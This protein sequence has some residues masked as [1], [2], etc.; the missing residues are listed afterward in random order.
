[1]K[2]G[3]HVSACPPVD[4]GAVRITML[5]RKAE[6][7]GNRFAYVVTARA[8]MPGNRFGVGRGRK[9]NPVILVAMANLTIEMKGP[10]LPATVPEITYIPP[11]SLSVGQSVD[12]DNYINDPANLIT[13]TRMLDDGVPLASSIA[14]YDTA[15]RTLTA[16]SAGTLN[17]LQLE[18]TW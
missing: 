10:L 16:N 18:I 1:M 14:S 15:S 17:G 2:H 4:P 12:M 9:R 13:S 11:L 3:D 8:K 6:R 5:Q 7:E